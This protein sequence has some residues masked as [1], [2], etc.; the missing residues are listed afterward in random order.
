MADEITADYILRAF[1]KKPSP[2]TM[3][4]YDISPQSGPTRQR[5]GPPQPPSAP[6]TYTGGTPKGGVSKETRRHGILGAPGVAPELSIGLHEAFTYEGSLGQSIERG[7]GRALWGE[8]YLTA[9]T[10]EGAPDGTLAEAALEEAAYKDPS[11][12]LKGVATAMENDEDPEKFAR[13]LPMNR[14][15]E[16]ATSVPGTALSV[17]DILNKRKAP[18]EPDYYTKDD[19]LKKVLFGMARAFA[20]RRY[21]PREQGAVGSAI[22]AMGAGAL[23][24]AIETEEQNRALRTQY[25]KDYETFSNEQAKLEFEMTRQV[26]QDL[27]DREKLMVLDRQEK[28]RLNLEW[29]RA[30]KPEVQVGLTGTTTVYA[31]GKVIYQA[32]PV[33]MGLILEGMIQADTIMSAMSKSLETRRRG[34][35]GQLDRMMIPKQLQPAHDAAYFVWNLNMMPGLISQIESRVLKDPKNQSLFVALRGGASGEARE[36]AQKELD[37]KVYAELVGYLL[38]NPEMLADVQSKLGV[39]AL[40][41]NLTTSPNDFKIGTSYKSLTG[42]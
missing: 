34:V 18:Q 30:T 1:G 17:Q 24:G 26:N 25:Q 21:W 28:D 12:V 19:M 31:D 11:S 37:K 35:D 27:F 32:D 42:R 3:E 13:S 14:P 36:L 16:P 8:D 22:A 23:G 41:Q 38:A 39:E 33:R 29:W 20:S 2:P 10:G 4:E 15:S 7:L 9:R 40:S 5:G 6:M